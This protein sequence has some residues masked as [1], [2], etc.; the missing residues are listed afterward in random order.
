LEGSGILFFSSDSAMRKTIQ[1]LLAE[2]KWEHVLL[3][4]SLFALTL[5]AL[6]LARALLCRQRDAAHFEQHVWRATTLE[7]FAATN[8]IFIVVLA[9]LVALTQ[10]E[11]PPKIE[12]I[13]FRGLVLA[14]AIQ[15][16]I[17]S[18]HALSSWAKR[19]HQV[20]VENGDGAAVTSLGVLSRVTQFAIWVTVTLL[21][22]DNLGINISALITSL[23]IGGVAVALALQNILG[24][25]FASLS[26]ALDRPFAVGDFVVVDNYMGTVKH[27]G[28]KT[29]RVQSLSGEEL[30]FANNDL[31]KSRIHNFKRMKD[32]RVIFS[33]GVSYENDPDSLDA[34]CQHLRSLIEAEPKTRLDRVNIKC[35]SESSVTIEVVYY[36]LEPDFNLYMDIQHR[37]NL[38][39]LRYCAEFDIRFGH[40][41]R[42][43]VMSNA[44]G[45]PLLQP[46]QRAG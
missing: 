17:W 15:S 1:Y 5:I 7:C 8:Q 12:S 22:L 46:L 23:G 25:M 29:T 19:K 37:L 39:I 36:V 33:L 38:A 41:V 28:V 30:I 24:D 35:L 44:Q 16:G 6:L 31:L 20:S 40:P 34:L 21:V 43:H 10:I 3:A 27:V 45:I 26:I 14:F 9:L 42:R 4:I 11:L 13:P 2:N 32:R 18:A